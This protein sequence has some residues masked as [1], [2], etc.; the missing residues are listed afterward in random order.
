M[1]AAQA[2][3][4]KSIDSM[5]VVGLIEG[6]RSLPA[7]LHL[8]R[9]I[10]QHFRQHSYDLAVLI[11]Y[12]G[13]HLRV[14][15]AARRAGIPVLYYIAPQMW[16]WGDWRVRSL[17][18]NVASL[19]VI[20]PFEEQFFRD[21]GVA[22]KFVGHPLLDRPMGRDRAALCDE[23][24][25]AAKASVLGL[26]PGSRSHEVKRLWPAF[27]D[28]AIQLRHTQPEIQIVVAAIRGIHYPGGDGFLFLRDRSH[29]V[30]AASD[31]AICK[32]GTTT[33]EAALLETPMVV[34]Y[35][36]HPLS[37]AVARRAIRVSN[38]G[39]VNLLAG[40]SVAP[41]LLQQHVTA[42][43]LFEAVRPLLNRWGEAA[44]EQRRAFGEIRDRLGRPGVGARVADL[45]CKLVA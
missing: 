44:T 30:L 25:L 3:V 28:A 9:K 34:A 8:L 13:F 6:V 18:E 33:L 10:Q 19:A 14:A 43:N 16:A 37:Y 17:R 35:R 29:D 21:R 36:M 4:L 1:A 27:R 23:L 24:N 11:D 32:S 15:A 5:S 22:A 26:L 41:E 40:R 38:V 7:H 45:A 39:L 2:T 31:V 42:Q 20:L 12:P